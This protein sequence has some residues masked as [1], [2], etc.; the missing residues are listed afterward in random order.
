MVRYLRLLWLFI[1]TS[2][3]EEAAF[4]VNFAINLMTTIL[5]LATGILG[6]LILFNQV[7]TIQGWTFPQTLALLGVYLLVTALRD[8]VIGPSLSALAGIDGETWTGRFDYTLLKPVPIQFFVSVRKWRIWS[9]VDLTLSLFVLGIALVQ[10]SQE[11]TLVRLSAFLFTLFVAVTI[12]YAILLILASISFWGQGVPLD[13]VFN[14]FIQMGRYPVGIYPQW[15]RLVLT[16]IVPVGFITTV[17]VQS[18]TGDVSFPILLGGAGLAIGLVLLAS[19]FFRTSLQHYA[20][21][22][23]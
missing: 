16:W 5:N 10:L 19:L 13:F 9:F 3:Q 22:S 23:S 2:F 14:S 7:E 18:V 4:R 6:L 11:I 1:G 20:S 21:A 8:L 15:L 17:P 12:L